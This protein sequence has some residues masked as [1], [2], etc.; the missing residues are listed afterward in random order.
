[1]TPPAKK[2]TPT[3]SLSDILSKKDEDE[4]KET[5]VSP[6]ENTDTDTGTEKNDQ[7]STAD[8]V[9]KPE[10]GTDN[11]AGVTTDNDKDDFRNPD[12]V[13]HQG[14][15]NVI[16]KT[17]ADLAA[18]TP[19]ESANRYGISSDIPDD[20]HNNPNSTITRDN[21]NYQIPGGTHLHPD[22]ARTTY[23]RSVGDRMETGQVTVTTSQMVFATPAAQDDKGIN[24]EVDE[25]LS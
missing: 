5:V 17:P 1:M 4:T 13:T 21:T 10:E 15:E 14:G 19:Q 20:V 2:A 3:K 23:N 18:E 25:D 16:N 11:Q 12:G 6:S 24:N 9:K 8:N 22:I 7:T